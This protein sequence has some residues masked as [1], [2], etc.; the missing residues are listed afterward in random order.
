MA[1][2]TAEVFLQA[3]PRANYITIN[4]STRPGI[5]YGINNL[6]QAVGFYMLPGNGAFHGFLWKDGVLRDIGTLGGNYSE[7]SAINDAGQ[8]VGTSTLPG[9]AEN[10]A[11]LWQNGVMRDLGTLGWSG[12]LGEPA[13]VA[14]SISSKG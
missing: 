6:G 3:A 12:A 4:L 2:S 9:D 13:S 5:A 10:H 14:T 8:V 1:P 7:A 11:F